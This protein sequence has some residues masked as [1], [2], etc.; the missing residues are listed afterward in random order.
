MTRAARNLFPSDKDALKFLEDH[1]LDEAHAEMLKESGGD[2]KQETHHHLENQAIQNSAAKKIQATYLHYS[3]QKTIVNRG[4][5]TAQAHYWL[6]LRKQSKEIKWFKN[7][8]YY[9][10]FRVPLAYVLVCLDLVRVFL[11]SKKEAEKQN[12]TRDYRGPLEQY[13][14]G[15][16]NCTLHLGPI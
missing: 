16:V 4:P 10:L 8:Q 3:K 1:G 11:E 15:S 12:R 13:R 14:Y 5:K 2:H 6:L 9:L 7:S